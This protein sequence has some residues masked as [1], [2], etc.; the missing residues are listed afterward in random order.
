M[1]GGYGFPSYKVYLHTVTKLNSSLAFSESYTKLGQ[2]QGMFEVNKSKFMIFNHSKDG[3]CFHQTEGYKVINNGYMDL[4]NK[5]YEHTVEGSTANGADIPEVTTKK[6]INGKWRTWDRSSATPVSFDKGKTSKT[7]SVNLTENEPIKWLKVGATKGQLLTVTKNSV[8]AD[9]NVVDFKGDVSFYDSFDPVKEGKNFPVKLN[10]KGEYYLE[11]SSERNLNISLTIKIEKDKGNSIMSDANNLITVTSVG[12]IKLG[13][14]I[15]EARKVLPS[16]FTLGPGGGEGVTFIGVFDGEK[17]LMDIGHYGESIVDSELPPIDENQTI[18][19]ITI[20]DSRY[21]TAEGVHVE[22]TIANAEKQYGKITEM[23]NL[24]HLGESVNSAINQ[25]KLILFSELKVMIS[26]QLE[27]MKKYLITKKIIR[28]I[29]RL[30]KNTI[31]VHI[32]KR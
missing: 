32:L 15:G 24:P 16:G 31:K 20:L 30:Q 12:N 4:L 9:V 6:L 10:G 2:F 7:I 18:G 28:H 1:N 17:H 14:T 8:V 26:I 27:F 13:M 22:M 19:Q 11:L 21:K 23:F 29:V 3:C 5:V 25:K